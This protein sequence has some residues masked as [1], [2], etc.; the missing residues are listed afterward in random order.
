MVHRLRLGE[1]KAVGGGLV[2]GYAAPY[3]ELEAP[4]AHLV[5]H[6]DLFDQP[7][8]VIERQQVDEGAKPQVLGAAGERRHDQRRRGGGAERRRMVLGNVVA[9][10]A[11]AVVGFG[12]G[13]P[14]GIELAKRHARVVNV[15]EYAEFHFRPVVLFLPTK[16]S[17]QRT[18]RRLRIRGNA[19]RA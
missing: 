13:E 19:V 9:V 10:E 3:A 14:V 12:D 16:V 2:H 4:A 7:Q 6:A 8:R 5:E 15:V 17:G 11:C 1:I 18:W